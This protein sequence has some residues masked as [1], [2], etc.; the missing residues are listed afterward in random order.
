LFSSS[1]YWVV[2]FTQSDE[3]EEVG[4]ACMEETRDAFRTLSGSLTERGYVG[5]LSVDESMFEKKC[6]SGGLD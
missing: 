3:I 1:S 2:L 6:K 5:V 4:H